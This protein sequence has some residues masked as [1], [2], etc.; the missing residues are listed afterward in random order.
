MG[1]SNVRL[2]VM[3]L[4]FGLDVAYVLRCCWIV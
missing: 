2:S 4:L 1:V 3:T